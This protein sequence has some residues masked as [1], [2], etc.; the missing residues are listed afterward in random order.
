MFLALNVNSTLKQKKRSERVT[1]RFRAYSGSDAR[2]MPPIE[3]RPPVLPDRVLP[4]AGCQRRG[5]LTA[6]GAEVV[7]RVA[8][9]DGREVLLKARRA[10]ERSRRRL[11]HPL[12]LKP[13][14]PR[15]R[16]LDLVLVLRFPQGLDHP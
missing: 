2:I 1:A 16:V 6:G 14:S 15:K 12:M 7:Q 13:E 10:N 5:R 11:R 4:L 8:R 9:P 3:K